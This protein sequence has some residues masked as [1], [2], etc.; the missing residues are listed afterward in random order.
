ML[1]DMFCGCCIILQVTTAAVEQYTG[2]GEPPYCEMTFRAADPDNSSPDL[3]VDVQ[4]ERANV[5]QLKKKAVKCVCQVFHRKEGINC[6]RVVFAFFPKIYFQEAKNYYLEV[7]KGFLY[8]YPVLILS[9]LKGLLGTYTVHF[10]PVET[11]S[12]ADRCF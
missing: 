9:F 8:T 12:V 3:N 1:V 4:I 10:E 2:E 5:I 11:F 6:W 7:N